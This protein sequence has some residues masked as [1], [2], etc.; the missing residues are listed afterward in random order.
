MTAVARMTAF[1]TVGCMDRVTDLGGFNQLVN[2]RDGYFVANQNDAFVGR[3]LIK[4]GEY[5]QLEMDL[6][7]Q[8]VAP[9]DIAADIGAN[10]GAHTVGLA[11]LVGSSGRVLAFE[12]QPVIFQN[13][14]AN[15]SLNSIT[16]VDAF[17]C[18]IGDQPDTITVPYYRYDQPFNYAGIGLDRRYDQGTQVEVKTFDE[19]FT[20]PRLKLLK[21]DVEGMEANVLKGARESIAKFKPVLYL[22]NDRAD[23]SEQLIELVMSMDYRLW[24]HLP[25]LFNP[26]TFFGDSENLFPGIVSLNML[27]LHKDA[28]ANLPQFTEILEPLVHPI[29]TSQQ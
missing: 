5:S 26:N 21:I 19:V 18:G 12:P 13:L 11:K 20:Y 2:A 10:I 17:H 23:Q 6:L 3:A 1:S 4:Y 28:P 24:W 25:P 16:N 29:L 22:E 14:C 8:I 7:R 9:G 27:C 15:L